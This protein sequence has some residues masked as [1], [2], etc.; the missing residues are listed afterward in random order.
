MTASAVNQL[1]YD[2][3][4]QY[5]VPIDGNG[6]SL[7]TPSFTA[8]WIDGYNKTAGTRDLSNNFLP[9]WDDLTDWRITP[10]PAQAAYYHDFTGDPNNNSDSGTGVGNQANY[11]KVVIG[12][13]EEQNFAIWFSYYRNRL[14]AMKSAAGRA[15]A[16]PTL[17]GRV[18]IAQQ[19]M[20]GYNG[21]KSTKTNISLMKLFGKEN[22]LDAVAKQNR[23]DFFTWLHA[24]Q[25]TGGTPLPYSMWKAGEYY[26]D[27]ENVDGVPS[28]MTPVNNP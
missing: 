18:R 12:P 10:L 7:G 26:R 2:P 6:G 14:L 23:V 5:V 16:D 13:A 22:D 11:T 25:N 24:L 8:A 27:I 15:F 1:A 19:T 17:G 4:V 28:N 20:W 21:S 3:N 9:C